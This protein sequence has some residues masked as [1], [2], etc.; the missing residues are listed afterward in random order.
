MPKN[1]NQPGNPNRDYRAET[2]MAHSPGGGEYSNPRG[3]PGAAGGG[4]YSA[5]RGSQG[6]AGGGAYSWSTASSGHSPGGG[7]Y[8]WA[9]IGPNGG[10]SPTGDENAT[11]GR[12]P[13][14]EGPMSSLTELPAAGPSTVPDPYNPVQ[15]GTV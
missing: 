6:A 15:N 7:D 8:S 2:P 5:A 12:G 11:V 1:Y 10:E 14:R 3:N 13:T 9:T 4:Q